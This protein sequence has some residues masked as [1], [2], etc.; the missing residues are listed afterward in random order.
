MGRPW[1]SDQLLIRHPWAAEDSAR[2][3]S[4]LSLKDALQLVHRYGDC[5]SPKFEAALMKWLRRYPGGAPRNCPTSGRS[6]QDSWSVGN[7]VWVGVGSGQSMGAA[8]ACR[9]LVGSSF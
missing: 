3:M 6:W 9:R 7:G 1:C 4:R 2:E 5:G 8:H